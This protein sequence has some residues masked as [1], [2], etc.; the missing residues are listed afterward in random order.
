MKQIRLLTNGLAACGIAL[1]MVASASAQ[2]AQQGMA[3]VVS[4]KG[5]ARYMTGANASWVPLKVG[6]IVKPGAIIQTAS[7]SYV[8]MVLNSPNASGP[9]LSP[10][11]STS[12]APGEGGT[13]AAYQPK[14]QQ[15]VVRIFENT[16]LG[17]DKLTVDQTGVETIAETQLD[18]K[19]GSIFGTVKKLSA[20]SKYEI[21]IPNGVAGI[22]GSIYWI[23]AGGI[24]RMLTGSGALAYVGP[25][26]SVTTKTV[27]GGQQLDAHTGELSAILPKIL[28]DLSDIRAGIGAGGG[29]PVTPISP[30][31]PVYPRMS[32]VTP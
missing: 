32:P 5:S 27:I 26:G 8:D 4:I 15:D 1:A 18:L 17:I 12:S 23:T 25:D 22:R 9:A 16:V 3:K 28:K 11:T 31:I 21:K 10:M 7:G 19:A 29:A 14:A 30:V 24:L 13:G 2:T 20:G 6:T